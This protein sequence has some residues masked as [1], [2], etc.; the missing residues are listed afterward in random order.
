MTTRSSLINIRWF[1][2]RYLTGKIANSIAY[3]DNKSAAGQKAILDLRQAIKELP[4]MTT[5]EL[6]KC[7]HN[8]KRDLENRR[9]K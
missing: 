5:Q 2:I 4:G 7:Y 1:V 6:I 9:L 8:F 3:V